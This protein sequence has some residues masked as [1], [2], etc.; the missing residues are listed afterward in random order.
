MNLRISLISFIKYLV[1]QIRIAFNS[2][3]IIESHHSVSDIFPVC[4]C[5]LYTLQ[6]SLMIFFTHIFHSD[7][8]QDYYWILDMPTHPY[9]TAYLHFL[10]DWL[11]VEKLFFSM[12]NIRLN[13][14]LSSLICLNIYFQLIFLVFSRHSFLMFIPNLF[15]CLVPY[16]GPLIHG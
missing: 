12:M 14:L 3:V 6:Q 5:F 8:Q 7:Y 13:N 9:T 11:F 16:L 10:I 2:Q 15:S 4:S 1:I